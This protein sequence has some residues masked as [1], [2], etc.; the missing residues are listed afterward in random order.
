MSYATAAQSD[1]LL[2]AG[3]KAR[4]DRAQAADMVSLDEATRL[5]GASV[6][7]L[8]ASIRRGR[9]IGLL[10]AQKVLRLP[11]WQFDP[12]IWPLL[13]DLA[14]SLGTKDSWALLSFLET[15]QEA[16]DG[17]SPRS[18][19]E[20]L[21]NDV[22]ESCLCAVQLRSSSTEWRPRGARACRRGERIVLALAT[23]SAH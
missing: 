6:D 4:I 11:R 1:A 20:Q 8:E 2:L 22:D 21:E 19:L 14:S 3:A 13:Q 15:P 7:Q 9:C 17:L 16:L 18:L 12:A 5:A 10:D 23:A